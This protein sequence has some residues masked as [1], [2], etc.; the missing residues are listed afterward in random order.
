[1]IDF[2]FEGERFVHLFE[3]GDE[4]YHISYFGMWVLI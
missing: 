2:I 1:M 4:D 3:M